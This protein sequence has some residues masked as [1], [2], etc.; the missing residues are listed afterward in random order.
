MDSPLNDAFFHRIIIRRQKKS[1]NTSLSQY[2]RGQKRSRTR[3]ISTIMA[4]RTGQDPVDT[5][6]LTLCTTYT[7][8]SS[9]RTICLTPQ[10]QI[11]TTANLGGGPRKRWPFRMGNIRTRSRPA[12]E[13]EARCSRPRIKKKILQVALAPATAEGEEQ[14]FTPYPNALELYRLDTF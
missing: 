13:C 8:E 3:T 7:H 5:L 11:P 9:D 14:K 12:A 10:R 1:P 4:S 6:L 2:S